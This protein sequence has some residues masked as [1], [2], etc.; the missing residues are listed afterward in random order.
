M[1]RSLGLAAAVVLAVI[2][3]V[4]T[5]GAPPRGTPPRGTADYHPAV[6]AHRPAQTP[7]ERSNAGEPFKIPFNVNPG[8]RPLPD[9]THRS[10]LQASQ[11]VAP[12][13]TFYPFRWRGLEWI[14]AAFQPACYS[15]S[16]PWGPS[17]LTSP[18]S[19]SMPP[20]EFTIGS[21]VDGHSSLLSPPSHAQS[22]AAPGGGVTASSQLNFQYGFQP[23]P[24]GAEFLQG[25]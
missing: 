6:F 15:T 5:L 17:S 12:L 8:P 18:I 2:Q 25:F 16:G 1:I 9:L 24:C 13:T 20:T 23:A 4:V 21:L 22:I 3:P 11:R 10:A 19:A 7:G 14:P